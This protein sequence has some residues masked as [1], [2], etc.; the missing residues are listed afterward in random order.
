M[1]DNS[2]REIRDQRVRQWMREYG[3]A[4]KRMCYIYLCDANLV[5]DA[6]Q[7]TFFKAWKS[8]DR[9]EK[10]NGCSE[11]TWLTQIAINTCRSYRRTAWFRRVDTSKAIEN[12][13]IISNSTEPEDREL[14]MEIIRLPDI[15]KAVILL[16]YYQNMTQQEISGVLGIS[17]SMVN[18]QLHKALKMLKIALGEEEL[19]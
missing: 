4:I 15:Y 5:E 18:Y 13:T 19:R 10:R 8:F 17:R 2:E 6:L 12:I 16:H 3:N 1:F 11:K 7:E 14:L 9:F